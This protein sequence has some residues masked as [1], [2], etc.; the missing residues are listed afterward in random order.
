M[1]ICRSSSCSTA[2]HDQGGERDLYLLF[3]P[4]A[5]VLVLLGFQLVVVL[6]F[7]RGEVF[8]SG[9]TSLLVSEQ[10]LEVPWASAD[11]LV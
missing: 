8:P 10:G 9:C 2:A 11:G 7:R 5:D 3:S 4:E 6:F 1:S